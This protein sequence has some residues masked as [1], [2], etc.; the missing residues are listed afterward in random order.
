LNS[1][2]KTGVF[3]CVCVCLCACKRT[4]D[5]IQACVIKNQGHSHFCHCAVT[6]VI[7]ISYLILLASGCVDCS[8]Y[9]MF[10]DFA[11]GGLHGLCLFLSYLNDTQTI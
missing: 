7:M 1:E 2:E 5:W 10:S 3:V 8:V 11:V 6:L 9:I 4:S